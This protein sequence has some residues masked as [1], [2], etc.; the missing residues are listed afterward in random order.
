MPGADGKTR[1]LVFDESG[2]ADAEAADAA[3]AASL[4]E[5]GEAEGLPPMFGGLTPAPDG[6]LCVNSPA[7]YPSPYPCPY[8]VPLRN[9]SQVL[10]LTLTPYPSLNPDANLNPNPNPNPDLDS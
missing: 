1:L 3:A 5:Y 10:S 7:T 6:T 4:S 8:P 9:C 2:E